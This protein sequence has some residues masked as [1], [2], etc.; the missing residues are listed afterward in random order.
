MTDPPTT[1][2]A[3]F[4]VRLA[5]WANARTDTKPVTWFAAALAAHD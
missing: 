3:Y 4:A 2:A 1:A 5:A